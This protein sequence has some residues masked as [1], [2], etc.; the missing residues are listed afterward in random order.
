MR[1]TVCIKCGREIPLGAQ[2]CP[3]CGAPELKPADEVARRL[4]LGGAIIIGVVL[5][6]WLAWAFGI[7]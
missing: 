3:A 1:P 4:L 6:I 5:A 2:R 7:F